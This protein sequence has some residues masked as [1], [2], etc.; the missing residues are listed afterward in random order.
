MYVDAVVLAEGITDALLISVVCWPHRCTMESMATVRRRREL[1][2]FVMYV[3][4]IM[5]AVVYFSWAFFP[6]TFANL[7]NNTA[8][9]P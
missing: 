6:S 3:T 1:L 7:V 2:G 4:S 8:P 9:D 5:A